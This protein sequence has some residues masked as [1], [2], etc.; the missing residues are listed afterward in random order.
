MKERGGIEG[1]GNCKE[2]PGKSAQ[3]IAQIQMFV[4]TLTS[5]QKASIAHMFHCSKLNYAHTP[6]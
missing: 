6:H 4:I 3:A 2:S 1:V 5:A